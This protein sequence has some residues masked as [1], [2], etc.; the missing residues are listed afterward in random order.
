MSIGLHSVIPL[1][2]GMILVA[3]GLLTRRNVSGVFFAAMLGC[4]VTLR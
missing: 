4:L 1:N 3:T 2:L